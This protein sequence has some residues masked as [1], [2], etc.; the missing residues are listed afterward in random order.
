MNSKTIKCPEC[1]NIMI[2]K[3]HSNGNVSGRCPVCKSMIISKQRS[4]KEKLIIV[5]K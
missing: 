3:I 5:K 2:A 1:L 4:E